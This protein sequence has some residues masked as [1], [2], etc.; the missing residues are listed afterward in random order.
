M[1][2]GFVYGVQCLKYNIQSYFIK[3]TYLQ[4]FFFQSSIISNHLNVATH[5]TRVSGRFN[6]FQGCIMM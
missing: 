1:D 2:F 5:L 4:L 6:H 3:N